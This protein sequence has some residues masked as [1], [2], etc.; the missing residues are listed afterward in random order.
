MPASHLYQATPL[1]TMGSLIVKDEVEQGTVHDRTAIAVNTDQ[2][3]ELVHEETL[4]GPRDID[5]LP[6]P[7]PSLYLTASLGRVEQQSRLSMLTRRA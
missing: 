6:A 7:P 4:T 3:T 5:L 2:L 1:G